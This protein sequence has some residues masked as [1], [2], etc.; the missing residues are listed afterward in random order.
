MSPD[1]LTDADVAQRLGVG[2]RWV[3]EEAKAGRI[4]YIKLGRTRRYKP[5]HVEQIL[6]D[7]EQKPRADESPPPKKRRK[8]PVPPDKGVV[9]LQRK[10]P[11]KLRSS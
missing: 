1:L 8:P 6:A 11:R 4:P 3:A 5:E 7:R 9:Q 10:T 2:E